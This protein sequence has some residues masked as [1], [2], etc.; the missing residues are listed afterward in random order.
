MIGVD[1]GVRVSSVVLIGFKKELLR[2]QVIKNESDQK[3]DWLR[4]KWMY[5]TL[6]KAISEV[7]YNVGKSQRIKTV[8]IE[9]PIYSWGRKNPKV[10]AKS[11]ML[12]TLVRNRLEILGFKVIMIN[13]RSAKK[14]AG[15]GKFSKDDM[16]NALRKEL[17]TI[18]P[19]ML[20]KLPRTKYGLETVADS[21][22]ISRTPGSKTP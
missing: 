13:N 1:L 18:Q 5:G 15:G 2:Y 16:I 6:V 17:E 21:Y 7:G 22:F 9:E 12:M 14:K 3:D 19:E 10:F 8:K 11:V 20:N 4:V